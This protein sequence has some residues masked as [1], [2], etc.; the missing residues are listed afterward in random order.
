MF[1]SPLLGAGDCDGL[2]FGNFCIHSP[3]TKGYFI[4]FNK[5]DG[6]IAY[7]TKLRQYAW[8]SPIPFFNDQE[9]M[10]IFTGD[11][12]GNVYLIKGKTGEI[13]ASKKIGGNFESSPIVVEDKVILGSR[14][15]KIYKIALE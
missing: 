9:E 3:K 2:I 13:V 10:F 12:N 11:C 5:A 4:A 7:R 15:T 8:S 14:G 1:G 6:S